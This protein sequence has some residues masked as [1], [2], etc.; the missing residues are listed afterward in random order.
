[1]IVKKRLKAARSNHRGRA[2]FW[3]QRVAPQRSAMVEEKAMMIF[4]PDILIDAQFESS[5]R[6]RFHLDPERVL[7]LAVLQDAV[8]CFQEYVS[9]KCKRKQSMHDDAQEWISNK[10]RSY[11]F[12]F[13]NV[14]EALGFD[15]NYMRQ[16]LARWKR[17]ARANGGEK[18]IRPTIGRVGT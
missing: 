13:E 15:A 7:M 12:S 5:H 6:R 10:D 16:G 9:A 14:C 8:L 18:S 4:Q 11:L 3:L 1:M 2:P 17:A